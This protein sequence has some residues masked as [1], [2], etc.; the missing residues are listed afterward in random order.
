MQL[1]Q[2]NSRTS[3][4]DA[5]SLNHEKKNKKSIPTMLQVRKEMLNF[6]RNKTPT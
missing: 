1:C 5:C 6:V 2:K 3:I 4:Y